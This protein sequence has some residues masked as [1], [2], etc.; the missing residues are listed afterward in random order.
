MPY[1]YPCDREVSADFE[2]QEWVNEIF[3]YGFLGNV[4]SGTHL[5]LLVH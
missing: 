5:G 4:D 2:L 1:Y 3:H